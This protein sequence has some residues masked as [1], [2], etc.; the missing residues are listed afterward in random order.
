MIARLADLWRCRSRAGLM[1][2]VLCL[3]LMAS[4]P[5]HAADDMPDATRGLAIAMKTCAGCHL[6]GDGR[7]TAATAGIPS[8]RVIAN[9][10]GQ[11]AERIMSALI[12]PHPPMPDTQL[13]QGEMKDIIAYLDTLRKGGIGKPGLLPDIKPRKL[14]PKKHVPS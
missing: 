10:T 1:L 6:I 9:R 14:P 2:A 4:R 12:A 3:S 11:S 7:S 13:T 8:F 5:V